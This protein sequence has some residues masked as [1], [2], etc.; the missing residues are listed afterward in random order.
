[1]TTGKSGVK[2]GKAVIGAGVKKSVGRVPIKKSIK[3]IKGDEQNERL[4]WLY[5]N[6]CI[7]I[8]LAQ[9]QNVCLN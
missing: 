4:D 2:T 5:K 8:Y 1:M 7:F 9:R 6:D 3:A